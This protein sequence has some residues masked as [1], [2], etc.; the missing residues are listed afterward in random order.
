MGVSWYFWIQRSTSGRGFWFRKSISKPMDSHEYLNPTSAHPPQVSRNNP[1]SAAPGDE[2]FV[3][4][5]VKYKAYM[6]QSGYNSGIV[7]KHFIKVAKLKRKAVLE[8]KLPSK[9]KLES[10]CIGKINFVTSWDPMFLDINKAL[11]KFQHILED[12]DQCK[13]LFPR[14]TFRVACKRGHK[15]LKELIAPARV[16]TGM[17]VGYDLD[18]RDT[19]GKCVK[20]GSCGTSN[21]GR[22]RKSGIYACQVVKEGSSFKS[23]QTGEIYKIRQD[24]N[25]RSEIESIWSPAKN[26]ECRE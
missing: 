25:C 16:N 17:S 26:A 7:D 4:N 5:L 13:Q 11:R 3:D 15:N 9:R 19:Q 14:G 1:Y 2:M 20:C 22:K 24:I 8:G 12:D 23:N 6:L 18:D 21:R 10:T